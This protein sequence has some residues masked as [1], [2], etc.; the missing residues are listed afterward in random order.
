MQFLWRLHFKSRWLLFY[1]WL[2]TA[3][4]LRRHCF[5]HFSSFTRQLQHVTGSF[6]LWS[7]SPSFSLF[8]VGTLLTPYDD[9]PHCAGIFLAPHL[10]LCSSSFLL[11]CSSHTF[12]PFSTLRQ[13]DHTPG[14]INIWEN[15]LALSI[16]QVRGESCSLLSKIKQASDTPFPD[17]VGLIASHTPENF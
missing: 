16:T 13:H 1:A 3:C 12:W 7:Y 10:S 6:L 2:K 11:F 9:F 5:H 4:L 8:S 15:A 14:T 17:A